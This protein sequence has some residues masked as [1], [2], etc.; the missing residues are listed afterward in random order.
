[1]QNRGESHAGLDR[2]CLRSM[3]EKKLY[4]HEKQEEN[5]GQVSLQEILFFLSDPHPA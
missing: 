3:Q 2:V 4:D 1:M 5:Y